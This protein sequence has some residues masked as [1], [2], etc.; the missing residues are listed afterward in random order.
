MTF[1]PVRS[2]PRTRTTH[3][4]PHT[5]SRPRGLLM[6]LCSPL[7]AQ[8]FLP[9]INGIVVFAATIDRPLITRISGVSCRSGSSVLRHEQRFLTPEEGINPYRW[10]VPGYT[11]PLD[12]PLPP[13]TLQYREYLGTNVYFAP[14]PD[15]SAFAQ[16]RDGGGRPRLRSLFAR[17]NRKRKTNRPPVERASNLQ[18]LLDLEILMLC[19]NRPFTWRLPSAGTAC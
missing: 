13:R 10:H 3:A 18:H 6:R 9:G 4:H 17:G 19:G 2:R 15:Y 16:S 1:S 5:R 7:V 12:L 8:L 14:A 11:A